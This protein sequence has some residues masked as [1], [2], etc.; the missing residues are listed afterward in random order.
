M[1]RRLPQRNPRCQ[2]EENSFFPFTDTT[3][4]S[5]TRPRNVLLLL[6]RGRAVTRLGILMKI[7]M[8]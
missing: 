6:W 5:L 3:S 2:L 7:V 8:Q 4:S 1:M